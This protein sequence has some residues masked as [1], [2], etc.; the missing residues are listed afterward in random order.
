MAA[1]GNSFYTRHDLCNLE[2]KLFN[3]IPNNQSGN[4][5]KESDITPLEAQMLDRAGAESQDEENLS[6]SELDDTDDDG[7]LLDETSSGTDFS[8]DDLDIPG[9]ELDDLN[10][11]IGEEDEEN[12]AWS[13]ADTE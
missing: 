4:T 5:E 8:G 1:C 3:M 10:E 13:E 7:E 9:A 12:N 6:R 2:D 11:E